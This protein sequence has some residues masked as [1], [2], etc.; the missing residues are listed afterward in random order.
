SDPVG[1]GFVAS[2][3]HPGGNLTGLAPLPPEKRGK[4][5]DLLKETVPRLSHLAVLGTSTEPGNALSLKETKLTAGAFGVQIQYLEVRDPRDMGPTSK[6]ASK[7]RAD[8][9]LVLASTVLNSQRTQI[10]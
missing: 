10:V 7:G 2:L 9:V 5:R 4:R 6:A 3:A 1:N 8:A